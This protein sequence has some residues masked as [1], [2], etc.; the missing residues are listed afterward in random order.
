MAASTLKETVA[1][2]LT[3]PLLVRVINFTVCGISISYADLCGVAK[4][5]LN[6]GITVYAKGNGS[7]GYDN[8]RDTLRVP[9]DELISPAAK[10][11]VVHEAVHAVNDLNGRS[12]I[13]IADET[14]GYVAH[15]LYLRAFDPR[16]AG[17]ALPASD[18]SDRTEMMRLLLL[19]ADQLMLGK[20]LSVAQVSDIQDLIVKLRGY[21][22]S[23]HKVIHHDGLRKRI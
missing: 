4:A 15:F 23:R 1:G 13:R 10:A 7:G 5:I 16:F 9:A 11:V 3:D 19:A 2:I 22:N 8:V 18:G 12:L 17:G 14:A 20:P 21:E 6:G